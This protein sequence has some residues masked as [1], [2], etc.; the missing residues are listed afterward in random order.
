MSLPSDL[1]L[2]PLGAQVKQQAVGAVAHAYAAGA[3]LVGARLAGGALC[4]EKLDFL[5]CQYR[6]LIAGYDFDGISLWHHCY[7]DDPTALF[8]YH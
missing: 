1:P 4:G 2:A 3:G 6:S 7:A 8:A 5:E